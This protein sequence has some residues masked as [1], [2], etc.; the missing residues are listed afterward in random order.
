MCIPPHVL[1][2]TLV[3]HHTHRHIPCTASVCT[4]CKDM[5]APCRPLR[6]C[7]LTMTT[8]HVPPHPMHFRPHPHIPGPIYMSW[9]YSHILAPSTCPATTH[10][11]LPP[12]SWY[13]LL[14]TGPLHAS[15]LRPSTCLPPSA[16]YMPPTFGPLHV[17]LCP[18]P[19][20]LPIHTLHGPPHSASHA[21][22]M[23]SM[24][25]PYAMM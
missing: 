2:L 20:R 16:L 11:F 14:L 5:P 9:P 19:L 13:V 24:T 8:L 4:D 15:H 1:P 12:C 6:Q 10:V 22:P 17:T 21:H 7:H 18:H 3:M 25:C 23:H